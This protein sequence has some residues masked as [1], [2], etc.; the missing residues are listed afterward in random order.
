MQ[1]RVFCGLG[2]AG[3]AVL[4][5]GANAFQRLTETAPGRALYH[6]L[7]QELS[8]DTRAQ[9]RQWGLRQGWRPAKLSQSRIPGL[10]AQIAADF[11]ADRV[12][13][14]KAVHLSWTETAFVLL[15]A[16]QPQ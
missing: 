6:V 8:A 10:H 12:V 5:A 11:R 16:E 14:V 4:P 15:D 3:M 2:V 7:N 13:R 1:R 9:L